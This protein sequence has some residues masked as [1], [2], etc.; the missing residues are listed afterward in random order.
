MNLI[1]SSENRQ[2]PEI[3]PKDLD[4]LLHGDHH[5]PYSILGPHPVTLAEGPGLIIRVFAP[6]A[7]TVKVVDLE[8][9]AT[10]AMS[11]VNDM[12]FFT[13]FFPDRTG[14]FRYELEI[15]NHYGQLRRAADPYAFSPILTDFDLHLFAEGNHWNIYNKLGAHVMTV[16]GVAGVHFAVWA[17]AARRVSVIGNFNNWDGRR[18]PMR[19]HL[20][21]VW[22]IF[23]PGLQANELYKFEIK[24]REGHLRIK[25][26][27]YAFAGELR[28]NNASIV[29]AR[30]QHQ[31]QD[32]DWMAA[33]RET[34]WLDRPM[35]IYEVHLGSWKRKGPGENDW[36]S[37][38]EIAPELAAYVKDMGYTHVELMPLM[39]HPYDPSWGYQVT[40][41]FA[42]TRRYGLPEDFAY[43]VDVMHRNNIGVI[44]DWVP[45]HFPKDDWAL[46]WFD[47]TAL[48]E[49]LDPRLGEHPD[50]GTL[51]FNYGRNEVR[52]FLIASA[53]FW[54]EEY[55]ID[56]LR[57]DAVASM[58]YLDYSRKEGQWL[59]NKFGGREN[60]EAIAFIKTLNEVVHERFPGAITIAEESTAWPMVSRPT[61]LGGLGFTFKWNMGWMNDFLRYMRE[62]PIHRKYHQNLIT[63]SLY[64]A[65]SENFILPL[66][67]DE[68]VH[69]KRSLLDKMPGDLW[70]KLANFRV[71][72]GY[73]YGH[74]G[75]KLTFMGSEFGQWWEWNH[76]DSLQWHLLETEYHRQLQRYV[77]DLNAL[78]RREPALYEIDYSWEGFQWIDFQDFD[79]SLISFLRRGKNPDEVLIF[80]CNF[81]P[82]PRPNYR[83]GVPFLTCYQ[84]I[85][86]SDSAHYGGSNVG[87]AGEV[88]AQ[89]QPHHNQPY[90]M[91][92]TFPP[93]AV[94]VF[95]GR[96]ERAV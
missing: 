31:W 68:V 91:E 37:Y 92:I 86:N 48:Y 36:Y 95:K 82:V 53:L 43:F 71:A 15:I 40:G 90:S 78:Y 62:D 39:E 29:T 34:L 83:I 75:K 77:K 60:L 70:Q 72:L 13:A 7:E 63:F 14:R 74:P 4:R 94:L 52:N 66:S 47:G 2:A 89:Q 3:P 24:T 81:T 5:D 76:A 22:E 93:L 65:F 8:S 87:N 16:E 79:A 27:P 61:Y 21:G 59:P 96:R 26:D 28:P 6:E 85:L 84:E 54:L 17:P 50:W 9:G 51:I 1:H 56:G 25:S 69:G 23:I 18:H 41:Y 57:V 19:V 46:R 44:M 11:K 42:V 45:A 33:R 88:H 20:T 49:H 30:N 67:H 64:Y 12:G 32:Q 58:L 73:M 35:S 38:R 55:H 10:T 80:A